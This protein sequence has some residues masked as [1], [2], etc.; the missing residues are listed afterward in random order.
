MKVKQDHLSLSILHV[1][2]EYEASPD[3]LFLEH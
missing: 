1:P 3:K 2:M